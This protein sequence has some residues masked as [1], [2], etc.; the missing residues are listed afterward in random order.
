ML[1]K[2]EQQFIDA[3]TLDTAPVGVSFHAQVPRGIPKFHGTVPAG[4][5]FWAIAAARPAGSSAFHTLPSDHFNCAIGSHTHQ[6]D[7]PT[8][9][10]HELGDVLAL[11]ATIGYVRPE[12]VPQIPRWRTAPAAVSYCRLGD[13]REL[14]DVVVFALRPAAAMLLHEAAMAGGV[15]AGLPP[16]ARP[17][18]MAVPAAAAKGATMSLGCIG[19]RVYTELPDS[20]IYMMLPGGDLDAV[21]ASLAAIQAANAQLDAYHRGRKQTLL[22]ERA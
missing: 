20:H 1:R 14:P 5:R 4:C 8:E 22:D 11:F 18:C 3:L 19:N 15:A 7:L 6:I 2:L 17:T 12:E 13:A 9:R 21:A 16:L 10:A